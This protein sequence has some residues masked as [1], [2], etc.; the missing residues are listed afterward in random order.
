M[1]FLG[2]LGITG[3]ALT[4]ERFRSDIILQN[5]ANSETT[6]T[7]SGGPYRRKQVTFSETPLTFQQELDRVSG[8]VSVS[9]V[10]ESDRAFES[11]Y[12]PSNPNADANGYVLYPNVDTTE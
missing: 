4:A 7:E 10:T 3:S 12:D 6:E 9:E 2:S 5:I 1:G 8:G 11:V